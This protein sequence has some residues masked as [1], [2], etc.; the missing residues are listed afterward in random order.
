MCY[1]TGIKVPIHISCDQSVGNVEQ[2]VAEYINAVATVVNN[3]RRPIVEELVYLYH[4]TSVESD[5]CRYKFLI[6][7]VHS[8]ALQGIARWDQIEQQ[9]QMMTEMALADVRV[10][11]AEAV[12]SIILYCEV[13]TVAALLYLQQMIDSGELSRLFSIMLCLLADTDV[14]AGASLSPQEY[15]AAFTLL[16]S[17]AGKYHLVIVLMYKP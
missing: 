6:R 16:D 8:R 15:D 13:S 12:S 2:R 14:T 4:Q 1:V 9:V 3:E 5:K 17:A 11:R 10:D 7:Q